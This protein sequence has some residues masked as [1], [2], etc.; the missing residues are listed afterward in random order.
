MQKIIFTLLILTNFLFASIGQITA[1]VGEIKISRDSKE[2]VAKLGEKLEKKDIVKSTQGSKA[3]ISM[4]DNTII[5]IGQNSTLNILDYVYDETKPKNSNASFAFMKGSFK[6]ITGEIG[7]LNK[8]KFKLKT[9]SASIGIRGTTILG[10]QEIIACTDGAITVT[11]NGVG[12]FVNKNELTKI[13]KD[14][15]PTLAEQLTKKTL[16]ILEKNF[17]SEDVQ[18]L[19]NKTKIKNSSEENVI[20]LSHKNKE[21]NKNLKKYDEEKVIPKGITKNIVKDIEKSIPKGIIKETNNN[22]IKTAK[23]KDT[24]EVINKINNGNGKFKLGNKHSQK[25]KD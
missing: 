1:L 6:S 17:F 7:K 9:K 18:E 22:K 20:P 25:T 13:F 21:A 4:N 8:E 14:K 10:N 3:Q 19:N 2:F 23:I 5:T 16:N 15:A 24:D 11:S 12:I